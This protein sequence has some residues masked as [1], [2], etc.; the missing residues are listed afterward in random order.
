MDPTE[1]M[2]TAAGEEG[3]GVGEGGT[4]EG[5]TGEYRGG[6][7]R[8]VGVY[9]F[10]M[11]AIFWGI[12]HVGMSHLSFLIADPFPL[13]LSKFQVYQSMIPLH[14][15]EIFDCRRVRWGLGGIGDDTYDS[16]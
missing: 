8:A 13:E 7:G 2:D 15:T 3:G 6:R 16:K 12:S 10:Y 4:E 14:M 11:S 1:V 5:G 9:C